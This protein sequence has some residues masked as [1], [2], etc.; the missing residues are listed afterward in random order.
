MKLGGLGGRVVTY[1]CK[2][3]VWTS[4]WHGRRL[5]RMWRRAWVVLHRIIFF[6]LCTL[7]G[8]CPLPLPPQ[9]TPLCIIGVC[10]MEQC[11]NLTETC[12][13]FYNVVSIVA[14]VPQKLLLWGQNWQNLSI[15]H[16]PTHIMH[17]PIYHVQC[18]CLAAGRRTQT[19]DATD[20][21][22]DH[23]KENQLSF[24]EVKAYKNYVTLLGH[25]DLIPAGCDNYFRQYLRQ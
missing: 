17:K 9:M 7:G 25:P 24:D 2:H 16:F 10:V 1:L 11:N 4:Q 14:H 21:W 3:T 19:G 5:A 18:A 23:Y 15:P 6:C 20:Q 12:T 8:N 22:R 13:Q